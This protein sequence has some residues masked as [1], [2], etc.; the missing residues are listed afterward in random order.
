[1]NIIYIDVLIT[2]NIFVDFFLILCTKQFLHIKTSYKKMILASIAGGFFSLIALFPTLP[3][4]LNIIIDLTIATIITSIAFGEY[5][6]KK[7]VTNAFN[8]K[9]HKAF[10]YELKNKLKRVAVYFS[11]TFSFYGI[12]IFIYTV[13]KPNKLEIYNDVIYFDI[14]PVILI[15]LTLI[16]YYIINIIKR[17]TKGAN[18]F[19]TCNIEVNVNKQSFSFIA[20]ID[21]GC[22]L[23]EPFSNYEVIIAETILFNNF[24]PDNKK[25]RLIPF[26]SLGGN[27]VI[28]GFRPDEVKINNK[29]IGNEIYIGLCENIMKGDV[30]ALIS[31]ELANTQINQEVN[32]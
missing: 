9:K 14:S 21:T 26:T 30:K 19:E 31:F 24:Q 12:M 29:N 2:V 10:L 8:S 23:K 3:I 1:M 11:F 25:I 4:I 6:I 17:M 18:G 28:K 5:K 27:G 7:T 13:F 20:K 32:I 16:C 15:I 22:T